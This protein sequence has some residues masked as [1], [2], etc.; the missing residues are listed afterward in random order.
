MSLRLQLDLAWL[1]GAAPL[2]C[3][4]YWAQRGTRGASLSGVGRGESQS[5]EP[6]RQVGRWFERVHLAALRSTSGVEVL[7][8]NEPLRSGGRTIGELDVLYR[9]EGCVVHREVAVKYYLAAKAGTQSSAWVGPGKR[10]RLDLKLNR[11]TTHQVTVAQ[12]AREEDAWPQDLPF[13]DVTEVLMLGAFFSPVGETRLPDGACAEV[14]HGHWYYAS[15]FADRFGDAP[16]CE[17]EKPWWL[18]PEHGRVG[19]VVAAHDLVKR[20][21]RPVFAARVGTQMERAFVVPDGWWDDLA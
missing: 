20:L 14:D 6:V 9:R 3:E 7:A 5:A 2:M 12:Q 10:D 1:A 19:T 21:R 4:D 15:E 11:L 16:W 13:P 17:L 18:S 8:A